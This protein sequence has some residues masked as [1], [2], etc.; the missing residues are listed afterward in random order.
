MPA[1]GHHSMLKVHAE[2]VRSLGFPK[3]NIMIPDD[4]SI[5]EIQDKGKKILILKE[6][7][8][9]GIVMVDGFSIGN[10]QE[11]VIRDRQN[12]A[13]DGIFVV[14]VMVDLNTGKLKNPRILFLV[15]LS[16]FA[17][18]KIYLNKHAT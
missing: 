13:Q 9:S 7:A 2:I 11:V 4:G 16:T 17:N 6:K 18:H 5:I 14:I 8:P 3:E 12:L 10:I 15:V 1:Y